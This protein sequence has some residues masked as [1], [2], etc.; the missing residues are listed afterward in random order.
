MYS[1]WIVELCHRFLKFHGSAFRSPM[2]EFVFPI[3]AP[4]SIAPLLHSLCILH[5]V[6]EQRGLFSSLFF[7]RENDAYDKVIARVEMLFNVVN[8][9]KARFKE[10]VPHRNRKNFT[11]AAMVRF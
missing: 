6:I 2:R 3:A 11:T 1:E 9:K 5:T 7:S 4:K 10:D 8:I